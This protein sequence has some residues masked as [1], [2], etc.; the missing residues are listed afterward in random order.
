MSRSAQKKSLSIDGKKDEDDVSL[1]NAIAG[2]VHDSRYKFVQSININLSNLQFHDKLD[3]IS[4]TCYK[5]WLNSSASAFEI[6]PII[7]NEILNI[8]PFETPMCSI[9]SISGTQIDGGQNVRGMYWVNETTMLNRS[10]IQKSKTSKKYGFKELLATSYLVRIFTLEED[11]WKID[12]LGIYYQLR[13]YGGIKRHC[14]T[15]TSTSSQT[16]LTGEMLDKILDERS[17]EGRVVGEMR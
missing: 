8:G 13:Q 2:K 11:V 4:Q 3:D 5:H 9:Y 17:P 1:P 10:S 16:C 6:N 12:P 15:V 14:V 7:T